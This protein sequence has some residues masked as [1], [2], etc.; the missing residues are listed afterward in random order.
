MDLRHVR[1]FVAT[2]DAGTVSAAA[3]DVHVTQPALSRQLRH[4][5]QDL[6]VALFDRG[7]GRLTVNRTGAALLPAARELLRAAASLQSI[8]EFHSQGGIQSL[9]IAAPTVTLTDIVSPFVASMTADD[10]V[11]DVRASD[12][13]A[14]AA[15]IAGGADLAIGSRRP[16]RTLAS[17]LLSRLP[18]WAYVRP[19]DPWANREFVQ[20][21]ELLERNLVSLSGTS[22][23]REALDAVVSSLGGSYASLL[24]AANGTIAQ[25]LAASGRGVAVVSDDARFDLVPVAIRVDSSTW[26]QIHLFAAWDRDSVAAPTIARIVARLGHWVDEHYLAPGIEHDQQQG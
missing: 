13:M 22:H 3:A 8:A 15:M 6:G 21:N 4:L 18:V 5:E 20:L 17:E 10:P 23:A 25:A 7:S 16:P 19:D 1:Y 12:G 24:E 26:L 9:T 14:P 2:A 11:V